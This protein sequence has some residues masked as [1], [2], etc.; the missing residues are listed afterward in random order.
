MF[1]AFLSGIL[2][3]AV[4]IV[5][6]ISGIS[7]CERKDKEEHIIKFPDPKYSPNYKYRNNYSAP[8]TVYT[9][10]MKGGEDNGSQSLDNPEQFP[11]ATDG[12]T[13][14]NPES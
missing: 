1:W 11:E 12:R 8:Y 2:V 3:V 5:G 6:I 10:E 7:F 4:F 14:E 13:S 9:T